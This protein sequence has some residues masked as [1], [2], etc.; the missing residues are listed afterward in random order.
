[1]QLSFYRKGLGRGRFNGHVRR[2]T[3]ECS[4]IFFGRCLL[5]SYDSTLCDNG[6]L[7]LRIGG[8]KALIT[9]YKTIC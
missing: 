7:T 6:H 5:I 1:L 2:W 3:V 4:E 8:F 9:L